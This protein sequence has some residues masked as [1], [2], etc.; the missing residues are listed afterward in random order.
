MK[1]F[2]LAFKLW[3]HIAGI[4]SMVIFA[5][6]LLFVDIM[7]YTSYFFWYMKEIFIAIFSGVIIISFFVV[8]AYFDAFNIKVKAKNKLLRY[9]EIYWGILWRALIILIPIIGFIAYTYHG[10]ITSRI[11]TIIIEILVGFPTIWWFLAKIN[12]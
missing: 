8:N 1:N 3:F 2:K 6:F 9:F 4:M 11:A 7:E 5:S 12:K 10:S